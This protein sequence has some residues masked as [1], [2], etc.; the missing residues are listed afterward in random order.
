MKSAAVTEAFAFAFAL[1]QPRML[2]PLYT[3]QWR[4]AIKYPA[5][6]NCIDEPVKEKDNFQAFVF[7]EAFSHRCKYNVIIH[8][9]FHLF[10]FDISK[11]LSFSQLI[12]AVLIGIFHWGV[13]VERHELH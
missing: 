9:K 5:M 11:D 10:S 12:W 1:Y 2:L 3:K 4:I 6:E 7:F 8:H 13:F